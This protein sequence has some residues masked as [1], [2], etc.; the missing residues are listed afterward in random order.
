MSAKRRDNPEDVG[1]GYR[2]ADHDGRLG[3]EFAPFPSW[4]TRPMDAEPVYERKPWWKFWR[5]ARISHYRMSVP[6]S[7][8]EDWSARR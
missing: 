5:R 3:W 2:L 8:K 4:A 1:F 6:V 7:R